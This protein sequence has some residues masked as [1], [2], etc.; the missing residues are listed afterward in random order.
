LARGAARIK[1]AESGRGSARPAQ[2]VLDGE[3]H[4]AQPRSDTRTAPFARAALGAIFVLVGGLAL[5]ALF[6]IGNS[7]SPIAERAMISLGLAGSVLISA[8]AQTL[9]VVGLW[10]LWRAA[11]RRPG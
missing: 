3:A 6:F 10:L 5:A 4:L 1:V 11:R 8:I 9:V 7:R 2:L